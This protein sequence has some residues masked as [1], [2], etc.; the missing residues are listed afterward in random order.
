MLVKLILLEFI[1][2][3]QT[4]VITAFIIHG[5]IILTVDTNR[6]EVIRLL[7]EA[8]ST[9]STLDHHNYH[10]MTLLGFM[11]RFIIRQGKY[12]DGLG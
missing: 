12:R 5:Y 7:M 9:F 4:Y 11:G 6:Q 3:M 8:Y 2:S 1:M 10:H